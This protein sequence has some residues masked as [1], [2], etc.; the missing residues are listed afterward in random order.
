MAT[1]YITIV[2]VLYVKLMRIVEYFIAVIATI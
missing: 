1:I 2:Q